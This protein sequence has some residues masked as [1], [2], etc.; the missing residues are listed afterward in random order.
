MARPLVCIPTYNE[1]SNILALVERVHEAAPEADV[2]VIDDA[3][4]DGTGDL[5]RT[6]ILKDARL[7]IMARPAKLG[8][9]T[10]YM[11]SF[12]YGLQHSYTCVLTMDSDFSHPP[13][14]IPALI[15]AVDDGA[16]LS[17]GSRY[18]PGGAIEGWAANRRVLSAS[19]N[20]VARQV[21]RLAT[22]DCTGGFRCYSVRAL[23]FLV[24]RPLRSSGYS[25]LVE[26]LTRC[27][28]AGL[29]IVELPITFTERVRGQSKISQQEILRAIFTVLRLAGRRS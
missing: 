29:T 18:V 24:T 15:Q 23:Q 3:S 5:V 21:L 25:A 16:H 14:R 4:P 10:A 11:A 7:E 19:A 13:A 27:E 20:F 28:R 2:L 17:V 22:H 6:Q 9:G 8:L 12:A 1:A 26:L